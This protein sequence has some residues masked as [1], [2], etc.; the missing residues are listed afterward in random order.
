[1]AGKKSSGDVLAGMALLVLCGVVFFLTTTFREVPAMLSQNVP[2]TFFPRL[3]V[4]AI[5]FL[6]IVLVGLGLRPET[7][8]REKIKPEAL[9]TA[10]IF[11]IAI[12]LVPHLGMLATVFLVALVLPVYWGERR[13]VWIA[14]LAI[15]LPVAIHIVFALALGMRL[16]RGVLW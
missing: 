5:A 1:M 9:V 13:F 11:I 14:I 10:V 6:S 16:P 12:A 8:E 4:G 7:R 2:P 3:V 15:G